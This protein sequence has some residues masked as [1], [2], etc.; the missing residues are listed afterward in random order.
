MASNDAVDVGQPDAGAF[1]IFSGMKALEDSK[2]FINVFHVEAGPIVANKN[3]R[4]VRLFPF[5]QPTS[6]S[7]GSRGRVYLTALPRRFK[8]TWRS[9]A[10][11]PLHDRQFAN[12]PPNIPAPRFGFQRP[13]RFVAQLLQ[14]DLR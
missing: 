10:K 8:N 13:D 2:W 4:F 11:S 12:H 14:I 7:A 1:K 6:I 5:V 3:D 9:M